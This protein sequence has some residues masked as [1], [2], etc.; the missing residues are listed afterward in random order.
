MT[1]EMQRK[2]T[3]VTMVAVVVMVRFLVFTLHFNH[4]L[5]IH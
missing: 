3:L 5:S 4:L 2:I 1:L